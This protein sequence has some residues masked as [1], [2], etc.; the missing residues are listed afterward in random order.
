MRP[1]DAALEEAYLVNALVNLHQENWG[2]YGSGS[3]GTLLA[4][5]TSASID[6]SAGTRSCGSWRS[7]GS[8]VP[9]A[10]GT[11]PGPP[12]GTTV[13]DQSAPRHL[14]LV[15]GGWNAPTGADQLWV[16]DF[17]YVWTLAG[18][19]YVAFIVDAHSRRILGWRASTS[20]A[21]PIVTDALRQALDTR[22]RN[23][24]H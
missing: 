20:R 22:H 19:V 21:A 10:L 2:V 5:L 7:P 16:A 15:K 13:R 3:S 11:E 23:D 18:F 1:C 6:H 24:S 8:P 14:D 4:A 12:S 17:S 9:C